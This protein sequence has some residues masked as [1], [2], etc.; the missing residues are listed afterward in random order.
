MKN[1]QSVLIQKSV[2]SFYSFLLSLIFGE[3]LAHLN[4]Y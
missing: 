2:L 4:F 3:I 1:K